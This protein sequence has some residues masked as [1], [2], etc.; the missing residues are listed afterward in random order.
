MTMVILKMYCFK[1]PNIRFP[2]TS[3]CPLPKGQKNVIL[4][5]I[6]SS[7][8][9]YIIGRAIHHH[10]LSNGCKLSYGC[11]ASNTA[12][13]YIN[14]QYNK[15]IYETQQTKH[16]IIQIRSC[17]LCHLNKVLEKQSMLLLYMSKFLLQTEMNAFL[18]F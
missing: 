18:L 4:F 16:S 13:L 10:W 14:Y 17:L 6:P 8:L 3:L 12:W 1:G 11:D 15:C 2:C 7:C 5:W 9:C